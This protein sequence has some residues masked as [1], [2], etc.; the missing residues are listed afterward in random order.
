MR[1]LEKDEA[2]KVLSEI[3]VGEDGGHFIGDTTTHKVLRARYHWP[4]LFRDAH[5]LCCKCMICQKVVGRVKKE[6]FPLHPI[7]IDSPFQ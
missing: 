7:T 6:A 3:H 2:K 1:C 5:A 4:T